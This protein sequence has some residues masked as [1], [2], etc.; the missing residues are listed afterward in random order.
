M[1][2]L[3][4]ENVLKPNTLDSKRVSKKNKRK[5]FEFYKEWVIRQ[6]HFSVRDLLV[7]IKNLPG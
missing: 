3:N 2:N 4:S 1:N 5:S 7:S 6:S